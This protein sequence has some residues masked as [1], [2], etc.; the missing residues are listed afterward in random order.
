[1]GIELWAESEGEVI[2]FFDIFP[3]VK[4]H[5]D[6]IYVAKKGKKRDVGYRYIYGD[7]FRYDLSRLSYKTHSTKCPDKIKDLVQHCMPDIIVS[8][9]KSPILVMEI[10]YHELTYNNIAQR[11]PRVIRGAECGVPSYIFQKIGKNT[12]E[13][14]LTWFVK[15]LTKSEKI[16][17]GICRPILFTEENYESKINLVK[18]LFIAYITNDLKTINNI[19]DELSLQLSPILDRYSEDTLL[20]QHRGK[21]R[22]RN[23]LSISSDNS[24][25][26]TIIG[27]KR[28]CDSIDGIVCGVNHCHTDE[29]IKI[30]RKAI[31]K[32]QHLIEK[33]GKNVNCVWLSKG[34]GGLD[35][36]PG[37]VRLSQLLFAYD[38]KG[39]K[40]RKS[41]AY[42]REIPKDFWWFH[43]NANEIYLRLIFEFA[44]EVYYKDD[45]YDPN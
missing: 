10:T 28:N 24:R 2:K 37:L 40:I 8:R 25:V 27:V 14:P 29:D 38:E 9:D 21:K 13:A 1:M 22:K 5:I 7:F 15:T 36:Y 39:N 17:D 18:N 3:K 6:E 26:T 19:N 32:K 23:W 35:P 4:K 43:R 33:V 41:V 45:K 30:N 42:F 16:F 20:Y 34:T 44:D 31:R 11:L 12:P